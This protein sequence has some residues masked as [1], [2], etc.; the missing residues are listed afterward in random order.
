MEYEDYNN[1]DLNQLTLEELVCLEKKFLVEVWHKQLFDID[2]RCKG[3]KKEAYAILARKY[4]PEYF[5]N[6]KMLKGYCVHHIDFDHYN[7]VVS[8][9]V[10]LDAS[11]HK[12]IHFMFSPKADETRDKISKGLIGNTNGEGPHNIDIEKRKNI[13]KYI[14]NNGDTIWMTNGKDNMQVYP[15]W[16]DDMIIFGWWKG[17]TYKKKPGRPKKVKEA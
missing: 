3:R 8:N 15:P 10:I 5:V 11:E 16:V 12:T 17:L 14:H 13:G 4:W 1:L 2:E 7:D 9:L 6:N